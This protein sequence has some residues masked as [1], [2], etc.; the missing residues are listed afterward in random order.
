MLNNKN[1]SGLTLFEL[2]I[3]VALLGIIMSGFYHVTSTVL[4]TY[5]YTSKNQEL[6]AQAR[7]AMERLVMFVQESKEIKVPAS[8]KLEVPERLLDTYDNTTHAYLIDGDGIPDAD[9][10][11]DGLVDEGDGD[12]KEFI[13]FHHDKAPER[14][15]EI[16]PDYSTADEGDYRA[17]AVIC[18]HVTLFKVDKLA[19]DL[20][21]IQLILNESQSEV[22][23]KTRVKARFVQ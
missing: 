22:S 20:V 9:R 16:C 19:A 8:N 1:E 12:N 15:I 17:A 18:E 21:E 7:Y 14:L 23:L 2:I 5:D 3:A 6:L 4:T 10:D 11:A 13:K